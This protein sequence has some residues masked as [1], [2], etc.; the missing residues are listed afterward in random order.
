MGLFIK[1]RL[2]GY[3]M[4]M[5]FSTFEYSFEPIRAKLTKFNPKT[6][7]DNEKSPLCPTFLF[8]GI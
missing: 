4:L 3:E 7:P 8:Q 6:S 1:T 2:Q 5:T